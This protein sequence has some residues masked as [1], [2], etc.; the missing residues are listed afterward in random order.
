[1]SNT[2]DTG[3]CGNHFSCNKD[4]CDQCGVCR[5]CDAPPYFQSNINNKHFGIHIQSAIEQK[6]RNFNRTTILC[7]GDIM[8]LTYELDLCVARWH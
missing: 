3:L 8:K 5:Y 7:G 2:T 6:K 4:V 1:M